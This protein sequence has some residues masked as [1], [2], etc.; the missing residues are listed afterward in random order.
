MIRGLT[1]V[2]GLH[3]LSMCKRMK[4]MI[5]DTRYSSP[6][7]DFRKKNRRV[8]PD[9]TSPSANAWRTRANKG[10][11]GSVSRRACLA[12][13]TP[14]HHGS[15]ALHRLAS[16]R[17]SA[18]K[19]MGAIFSSSLGSGP[20]EAKSNQARGGGGACSHQAHV[21]CHASSALDPTSRHPAE[22]P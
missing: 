19:P 8:R 17:C 16:P 6:W 3:N 2:G 4:L 14:L 15:T 9:G 5:Y 1:A 20:P 12:A 13:S 18:I 22:R 7:E 11:T 21:S 10:R